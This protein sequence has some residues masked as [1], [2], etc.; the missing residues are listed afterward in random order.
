[1]REKFKYLINEIFTSRDVIIL[2]YLKNIY[3]FFLLII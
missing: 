3:Y 2:V 1:M